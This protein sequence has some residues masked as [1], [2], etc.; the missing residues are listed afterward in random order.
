MLKI[1][2]EEN[3]FIDEKSTIGEGCHIST[4][5]IIKNSIIEPNTFIGNNNLIRDSYIGKG[6]VIGANNELARVK[7]GK[8]EIYHQNVLIDSMIEDNVLISAFVVTLNTSLSDGK[9]YNTLFK[10]GCKVGAR[11]TIIA[12]S[13]IGINSIVGANTF[14]KGDINDNSKVVSN[15]SK[16]RYL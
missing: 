4:G 3:V 14:I 9:K 5:T 12:P 6:S 11:T 13:T 10:Q 7:T 16:I 15:G 8:V 1:I 2:I